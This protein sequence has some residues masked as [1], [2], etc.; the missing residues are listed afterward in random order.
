MPWFG[1]WVRPLAW[2][3]LEQ[4]HAALARLAAMVGTGKM[5]EELGLIIP[6]TGQAPRGSGVSFSHLTGTL[7]V[8]NMRLLDSSDMSFNSCVRG[9]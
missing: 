6:F 7:L 9:G 8:Q 1:K 4:G 3:V 5:E 2:G